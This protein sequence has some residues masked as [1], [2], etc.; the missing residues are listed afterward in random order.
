MAAGETPE[1]GSLVHAHAGVRGR[2]Q[3][4]CLHMGRPRRPKLAARLPGSHPSPP[5]VP[6]PAPVL[7]VLHKGDLGGP[8]EAGQ[9]SQGVSMAVAEDQ[10]RFR[11]ISGT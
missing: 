8:Q 9:S 5:R 10:C 7:V 2:K 11:C 6:V 3:V 1:D 4:G